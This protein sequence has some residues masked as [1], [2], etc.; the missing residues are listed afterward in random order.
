MET[1]GRNQ[2]RKIA[3]IVSTARDCKLYCLENCFVGEP[4]NVEWAFQ[5]L[6]NFRRAKLTHDGGN[7]YRIRVHSNHWYTFT[8]TA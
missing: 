3:A 4:A 2:T 1:I 6:A 5:A 7:S 8:A